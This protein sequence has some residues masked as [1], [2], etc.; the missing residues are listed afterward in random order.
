MTGENNESPFTDDFLWKTEADGYRIIHNP[1]GSWTS[2]SLYRGIGRV[3]VVDCNGMGER[4]YYV[5]DAVNWDIG[6]L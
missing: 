1:D 6:E 2:K 3:H 5:A 4:T